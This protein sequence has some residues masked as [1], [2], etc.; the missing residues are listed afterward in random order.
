M[1]KVGKKIRTIRELR[2]YSRH[3]M[4]SQLKLSL[5]SYGKIERDEVNITISRLSEVAAILQVNIIDI[6]N[7]NSNTLFKYPE[8]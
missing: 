7:F 2:D 6:L 4:A 8:S 3:Y 5:N 1:E